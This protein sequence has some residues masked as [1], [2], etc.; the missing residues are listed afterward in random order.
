[1][2]IKNIIIFMDKRGWT[3][4]FMLLLF[5]TVKDSTTYWWRTTNKVNGKDGTGEKNLLINFGPHWR[6]RGTQISSF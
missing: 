1:M 5:I 2:N 6:F 4:T 3:H